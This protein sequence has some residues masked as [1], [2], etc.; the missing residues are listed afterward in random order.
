MLEV[1][2]MEME[3]VVVVDRRE[4]RLPGKIPERLVIA[5]SAL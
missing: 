3:M 4:P 2:V 5:H 1:P